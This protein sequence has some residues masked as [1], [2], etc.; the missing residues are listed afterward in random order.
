MN[1][2]SDIHVFNHLTKTEWRV[3]GQRL[4]WD[5]RSIAD[6]NAYFASPAERCRCVCLQRAFEWAVIRFKCWQCKGF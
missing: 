1:S 4:S 6:V 5:Q 2:V 3:A